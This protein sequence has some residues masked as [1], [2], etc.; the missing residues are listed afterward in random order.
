MRKSKKHDPKPPKPVPVP[1][2][3][4]APTPVPTPTPS[5]TPA[6]APQ[7]APV[8][9]PEPTP[10]PPA[11]SYPALPAGFIKPGDLS[12][13]SPDWSTGQLAL[14][15]WFNG[16]QTTGDPTLIDWTSIPGAARLHFQGDGS[17]GRCGEL[18]INK[19]ANPLARQG[20][21]V[22]VIKPDAVCAVFGFGPASEVDYE[23]IRLNGE[24]RWSLNLHMPAANGNGRVRLNEIVTQPRVLLQ[25][26][27]HALEFQLSDLGCRWWVDDREV[28]A[29]AKED[30]KG[31]AA[32]DVTSRLEL[33]ISIES[34]G[35][36]AGQTYTDGTA[37]MDVYGIRV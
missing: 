21:V 17:A 31:L 22:D 3:A 11:S 29:I 13:V 14:P 1:A 2:P 6:P 10:P 9:A 37:Q 25:P 8:P 23:L 15:N 7:P 33:M 12:R 20:A 26:G 24:L 16:V 18:Q 27:P 28:W 30:F 36:W 19:P 35:G 34:H 5:P 4:P 32:W